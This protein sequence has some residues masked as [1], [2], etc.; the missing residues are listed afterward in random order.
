[1]ILNINVMIYASIIISLL[2]VQCNI[3]SPFHTEGDKKEP[4]NL[5]SDAIAALVREEPQRAY[6][7][8]EQAKEQS[9]R[10]PHILYYHAVA[11]MR[12]ESI[13]IKSIIDPFLDND[14]DSNSGSLRKIFHAQDDIFAGTTT[15]E[16]K[17]IYAAF[18]EI[19]ADLNIL[20]EG[21]M[22]GE[23]SEDEIP[24][25][26]DVYLSCGATKIVNGLLTILDKEPNDEQFDRDET[27]SI[28]RNGN[29]Y[30]VSKPV[31]LEPHIIARLRE[32]FRQGLN[33]LWSFYYFSINEIR[34]P[35]FPLPPDDWQVNWPEKLESGSVAYD[36]LRVTYEGLDE[37]YNTVLLTDRL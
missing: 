10:D 25:L 13:V 6:L 11:T 23:F 14:N 8:L 26:D 27:I 24:F 1:M 31:F 36:I 20:I 4:E 32:R 7:L 15:A 12:K 21:L 22:T 37:L 28:M 17:K 18:E 2:F 5:L 3:F 35:P 33:C 29:V 34:E 30:E 9:P 19:G 16:L